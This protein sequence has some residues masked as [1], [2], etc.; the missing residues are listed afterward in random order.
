M[1]E[2]TANLALPAR[3]LLVAGIAYTLATTALYFL[4]PPMAATP[5]AAQTPA[6]RPGGRAATDVTAILNR[7]LFGAADATAMGQAQNTPT[8][9]TQLPLELLGVFVAD[10]ADASAA[11]VSQRGRQGLL[12]AVGESVPGNATLVEV[13][14]DH[15]VLRRGGTRE[16]L[17]FPAPG[18]SLAART[19]SAGLG[20]EP[21]IPLDQQPLQTFDEPFQESPEPLLDEEPDQASAN[22]A[23]AGDTLAEY[24]DRLEQDPAQ[25]LQELGVAPVADGASEGY[26]VGD[27]A[28][29][30]YLSQTGLQPGDVILSV[31]GRP[32]GDLNQDRLE[33]DN[34]LAEGSARLEVQRGTRRFFVTATL[35]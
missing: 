6:A 18:S 22:A 13:H 33:L 19:P 15:V 14:N 16:A 5:S 31:N 35:P 4:S 2:L 34:V 29:S 1:T 28:Q 27:L 12:Y 30:P 21:V 32:V 23:D 7:Q 20:L 26:R 24:R 11:I 17:Y 3:W 10:D 25:T 9:T 8:V